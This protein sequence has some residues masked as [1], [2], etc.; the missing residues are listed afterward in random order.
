VKT[1][2]PG[3]GLRPFYNVEG[4]DFV[5]GH[6]VAGGTY[7][8]TP[9]PVDGYVFVGGTSFTHTFAAAPTDCGGAHVVTGTAAVI[10]LLPAGVYQLSGTVDGQAADSVNP[11]TLPG[12]T[13]G[14][15]N[16]VVTRG[17]TSVRTTVATNGDC[18]TT[19]TVTVVPTVTP[20]AVTPAIT[21]PAAKPPVAKPK[22]P[23]RKPAAKPKPPVKKKSPVKQPKHKANKK[24]HKAP[25]TLSIS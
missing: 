20:T 19:T 23:V 3:V 6:P 7:T 12:N 14:I 5:D 21:P 8:F 16:V 13:K 9:I 10:C 17:D 24:P 11:A 1:F 2:I 25:Q 4:P 22:P 18:G 15:S